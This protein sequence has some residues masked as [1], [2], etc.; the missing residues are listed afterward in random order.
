MNREAIPRRSTN[1]KWWITGLLLLATMLNYMDRQTLASV[2]KRIT[3]EFNLSQ[4]QYGDIEFAFGWGFAA[5]SL[6]FGVLADIINVRWL[7]PMVLF[8]WSAMGLLSGFTHGYMS[9]L[10][11]RALLGFFESGQW[12]CALR[13]TQAVLTD[14]QRSLGNS[15]L[16]SG[17]SLGAIFTPLILR[18]MVAGNPAPGAWRPAFMVVG[19]LGMV[20]ILVW[21]ASSRSSD[22]AVGRKMVAKVQTTSEWWRGIGRDRR[23]WALVVMVIAIN[24]IWHITRAWLTKFLQQGRNYSESDALLISSA[25]YVATDVGCLLS[26]AAALWLTRRRMDPHRAR[27]WVFGVCS[28]ITGLTSVLVLLPKGYL[29]LAVLFI[30]GAAALGL[31]PCYYSFTQELGARH[32][33][34]VVGLLSTIGWLVASP[35]QKYFGKLVD[36]THSFDLGISLVGW[37]PCLA[38]ITMLIFWRTETKPDT[39]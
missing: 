20:W 9:M 27:L 24:I 2:A 25:F 21:L 26:G 36:Q 8:G 7:Y 32:V 17:A 12:P 29:L 31:F 16:Q 34:K 38:L 11:C 4:E 28:I 15:V 10:V 23:F 13:T 1:W 5:G 3:D 30:I 14:G 22:F 6:V 37:V 19:A 39:L 33:G 35:L 18:V